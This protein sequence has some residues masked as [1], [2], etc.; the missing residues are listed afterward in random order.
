[1]I[2]RYTRPDM[3][4]IWSD[5]NKFNIWLQIEI[6]AVEAHSKLGL[7][8]EEAV[9]EIKKKA[10]FDVKRI[11]EIEEK[12]KHDVVAFLTN[13]A[14]NV[15]EASRFI[16]Y[17]MTSSDILD[18]CL[19]LQMKQA[20]EIILDDLEKLSQVLRKKAIEQKYTL[21]I[22]RTHGVHAEPITLGFKFALWFEETKRNIE[23]MKRAIENISYG[24]IAGAVGTYDNVS[25]FVEK[26][27]CEK[28]GLKVEPVSTQIIQRDRHAE[29]L[30]TLAII[31]SS[32]EKFATEIRHLQRTEVL[33][34]EEFFSEGQKGSSAM[35]HKRNPVRCERVSGLARI[36]RA[37]ALASL[38]NI[39]LWHERDI[40]H[41]SVE[42]II[43]PDSTTLVDFMLNEMIDIIDKLIIY[44][45]R[46]MKNLN[47]TNG[48]IFS[49]KVLLKLIEKGLT[50]EKAY[51]IVQ[52]NAMRS[53]KTGENFAELLKND[54]DVVSFLSDGEIDK[55]FDYGSVI[56]KID[57]IFEKIGIEK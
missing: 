42:R 50:R 21:M 17:G 55:I 8:P 53:W 35:P 3:E 45:E 7:V 18:T 49:Q 51:E 10:K 37:N 38:E 23:R 2:P 4:K 11:L 20:G 15:G 46:M 34:V 9:E 6:L 43:I 41:S 47:L 24:K 52:R 22:G 5:E 1:M 14:E 27:V 28:L 44:P 33:E 39:T 30:T 19:A 36:V 32:L 12:V 25:P 26:Y 13:V 57:F 48:L 56:E 29:Y 16:H 40:S 31:A 54:S